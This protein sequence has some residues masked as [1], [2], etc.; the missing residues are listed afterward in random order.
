MKGICELLGMLHNEV[1]PR[2]FEADVLADDA[3]PMYHGRNDRRLLVR[4]HGAAKMSEVSISF[5]VF[6]FSA[7]QLL[8]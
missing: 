5:E 1:R 8:V 4:D 6:L 3:F 2:T 7:K